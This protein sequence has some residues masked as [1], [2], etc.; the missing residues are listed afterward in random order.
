MELADFCAGEAGEV[1][2]AFGAP[3]AKAA[4]GVLNAAFLVG[5][6]GVGV[7]DGG[8]EELLKE[9]LVEEFA[10]VV[11]GDGEEGVE[12]VFA[13]QATQLRGDGLL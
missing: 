8:M 2:G 10:P 11:G 6:V 7:V 9:G 5:G 3:K 12:G 13:H 4:V 1:G